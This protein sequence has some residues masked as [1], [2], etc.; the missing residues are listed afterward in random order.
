MRSFIPLRLI[1]TR[2][3][4]GAVAFASEIHA[5]GIEPEVV[6]DGEEHSASAERI[7]PTSQHGF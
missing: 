1:D 4:R 2:V 6:G 7:G 3:A 5:N